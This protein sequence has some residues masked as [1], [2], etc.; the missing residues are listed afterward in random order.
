MSRNDVQVGNA[1]ILIGGDVW[2]RRTVV[3][4]GRSHDDETRAGGDET[5]G[6]DLLAPSYSFSRRGGGLQAASTG[7]PSGAQEDARA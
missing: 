4:G 1:F 2:R 3:G 5:K 6:S 7:H